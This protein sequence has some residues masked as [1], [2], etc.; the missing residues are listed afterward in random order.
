MNR[1]VVTALA[2]VACV[3]ACAC[4]DDG[5][6]RGAAEI[7][8]KPKGH[9]RDVL[10]ASPPAISLLIRG[11]TLYL[12]VAVAAVA[13]TVITRPPG[14]EFDW[15]TLETALTSLRRSP[16]FANRSDIEVASDASQSPASY[17]DLTQAMDVAVKAGFRDVGLVEPANLSWHP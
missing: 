17:R 6:G 1:M 14:G 8:I 15:A 12:G 10:P 3:C 11:D 4:G 2:V 9:V 7:R 16:A 13:P 5:D